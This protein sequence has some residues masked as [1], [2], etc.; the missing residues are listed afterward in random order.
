MSNN[1]FSN[2]GLSLYLQKGA[3]Y[4]CDGCVLG[5]SVTVQDQFKAG[6]WNTS[7]FILSFEAGLLHLQDKWNAILWPKFILI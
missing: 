3:P 4:E 5:I 2:A 7:F 6:I 1:L